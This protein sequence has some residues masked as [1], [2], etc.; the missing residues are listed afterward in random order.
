MAHN[1]SWVARQPLANRHGNGNKT[2]RRQRNYTDSD[3][4]RDI[5]SSSK[6]LCVY[7]YFWLVFFFFFFFFFRLVFCLQRDTDDVI[8]YIS[9]M[10]DNCEHR[11]VDAKI[12]LTKLWM[13]FCS[14]FFQSHLMRFATFICIFFRLFVHFLQLLQFQWTVE[15]VIRVILFGM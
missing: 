8:Q 13:F 2:T 1:C 4:R 7:K 10:T 15:C 12:T 5:D 9:Q 11:L 6:C 3:K 14:S